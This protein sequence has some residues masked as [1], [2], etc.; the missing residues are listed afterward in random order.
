MME[1]TPQRPWDLIL[2]DPLPGRNS[3]PRSCGLSM[4]IDKGLGIR[5]TLDL[6]ELASP[7]IDFLKFGF[8]TSML[9]SKSLLQNKINVL[10]KHDIHPYP[11]GT[12]LELA[13][14]QGKWKD[15]MR[16][17][18]KIGFTAI[19]VSDGTITMDSELRR[20]LIQEAKNLGF[21]VL[22][23][24]GKKESGVHLP[25]ETQLEIIRSDLENGVFKVI[26]EG[27][28]S[29]KDV[30]VYEAN[31]T[32]RKDDVDQLIEKL[33][34]PEV[35]MWEAPLKSQ[36]EVLIS[37]FGGNVNFGNLAPQDIISVESLRRGLR[38]DTMRLATFEPEKD[39]P[40]EE[41]VFFQMNKIVHTAAI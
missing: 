29:G 14:M 31:G 33:G 18:K 30:G 4:V 19:E 26:I 39:T 1:T 11:G 20:Q 32:I 13:V 9:Y 16:A 6:M 40:Q 28:E 21:V 15:F 17:A 12:L 36:Q 23:E 3:K 24:V 34:S 35:I 5:E 2:K 27:R 25:I 41:P 10:R 7:Y 22:S 38:S 8:G 37:Q